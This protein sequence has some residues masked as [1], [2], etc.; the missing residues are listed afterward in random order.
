VRFF[1]L[2]WLL[3]LA[4]T[5]PDLSGHLS[6]GVLADAWL[7]VVWLTY[8]ALYLAP[9]IALASLARLLVGRPPWRAT[10]GARESIVLGV[11]LVGATAVQSLLRIDA[12]V[13]RI[14]G[15]HLN[16]FVWNLVITPGGLASMD[17]GRTTWLGLA[18][19]IALLLGLEAAL[20][21]VAC[22]AEAL[23]RAL[24]P[25]RPVRA[26][27]WAGGLF[28]ALSGLERFAFSA[29]D[30]TGYQPIV[31]AFNS[32]PFY[33]R[34]RARK[35]VRSLGFQAAEERGLDVTTEGRELDYPKAPLALAP[36]RQRWNVVWLVAE[37]LRADAL[38]SEVMPAT[39]AFAARSLRFRRHYSGGNG[40]RMGVFSMFYGI[41]GALWFPFLAERRSPVLLDRLVDDGYATLVQTSAKLT[42]PEFDRTVFVRVPPKDQF[43]GDDSKPGWQR[44]R[45]LVG[46][47]LDWIEHRDPDR[48]FFTFMFF[49][50][51]HAQ[52]HFPDESVVRRPY[53][54]AVDYAS[55]DPVRDAPLLKNRYL[56]AVHHLDSQ[57]AR[58]FA[59]LER[60]HLLD[61]TIV[62]VTGD[63]G[64]EFMEKG[65]WGHHSDFCEE[66]TLVPLVLSIPG[67]APR[68][69]DAPTSHLD[70][71]PTI[72]ARLGVTNPPSDYSLGL[73]LLGD[74]KR[75]FVVIA[76]WDHLCVRDDQWKGIFPVNQP[77]FAG[78]RVTTVD[79]RPVEDE[80]SYM[81]ARKDQLSAVLRN[82]SRFTR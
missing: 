38:D 53:C 43:E 49:E 11:A 50:S 32:L 52:Y 8:G 9:A 23:W 25:A 56:N 40:T 10:S 71:A 16:G 67:Q 48:P 1:S 77:G 19:A 37:S 4:I 66:Q 15:F 79:D 29:S 58:V 73:D 72:L 18:G 59:A 6:G 80:S 60:D 34:T 31:R 35:F 47:M 24:R 36:D 42:F 51:P 21:L 12:I 74:L 39:E 75:D 69:I 27:W 70:L 7:L 22:R 62:V 54:D 63:H 57:F 82:L 41:Y 76:D 64:E 3:T 68:A 26:A 55:L 46:R 28:L 13:A 61:S 17:N 14:F 5:T 33:Q 20:L 45:D 30:F 44:D 65:R 78:C 81:R 2:S